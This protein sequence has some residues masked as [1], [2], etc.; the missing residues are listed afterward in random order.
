MRWLPL[1]EQHLFIFLNSN[2]E[3]TH[4]QSPILVN[5]H[6]MWSTNKRNYTSSL[7]VWDSVLCERIYSH[8]FFSHTNG[9]PQ[10]LVRVL[11]SFGYCNIKSSVVQRRE[12][13]KNE[14]KR[15]KKSI[16]LL[17]HNNNNN[18]QKKKKEKLKKN[19]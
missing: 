3:P 15:K 17:V 16:F 12:E 9:C 8:K 18:L 14:K 4:A 11:G 10:L 13:E 1:S 7:R 5:T 19:L 2:I 6:N